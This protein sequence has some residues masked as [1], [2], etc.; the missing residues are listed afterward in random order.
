MSEQLDAGLRAL[1]GR[2]AAAHEASV[3]RWAVDTSARVH[4][5][6]RARTTA[7]AL[8]TAAVV[9][10]AA[11]AGPSLAARTT[12]VAPASGEPAPVLE[13]TVALGSGPC[14]AVADEPIE[15][16]G[17]T[18]VHTSTFECEA[19]MSDPRVSGTAVFTLV[20][21]VVD[22]AAGYTWTADDMV[23]TTPGGVW[24]GT[25]S[26]VSDTQGVAPF[27]QGV[28]PFD[29]GEARLVGEGA[30]AGL[31]YRFFMTGATGLG[32]HW[33]YALAGWVE[34]AG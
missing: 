7:L 19:Q 18:E 13:S 33:S 30:Y 15:R 10:G 6:R 24:R 32:S 16:T 25:A 4:R 31:V 2:A 8:V 14:R 11:L 29:Y 9:T 3:E 27:A 5:A 21:R 26:G 17:D 20:A 22:G 12:P 34:P 1:Q 23:L 28:A